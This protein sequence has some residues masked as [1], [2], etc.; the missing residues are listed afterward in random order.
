MSAGRM[1]AHVVRGYQLLIRPLLPAT[2]RFVPGCS[3]YVREALVEHGLLHGAGLE[4]DGSYD[5]IPGMPVAM[6]R[7]RRDGREGNG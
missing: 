3:E 6:I 4:S 1:A 7:R 2:C 5:V